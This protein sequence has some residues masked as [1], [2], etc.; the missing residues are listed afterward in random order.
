[1]NRSFTTLVLLFLCLVGTDRL[2]AQAGNALKFN[3]GQAGANEYVDLPDMP[4]A[5]NSPYTVEGWAKTTTEGRMLVD[6]FPIS[7]TSAPQGTAGNFIAIE[8]ATGG[9]L[10]YVHRA[11]GANIGGIEVLSANAVTSGNW[12]HYAAVYDSQGRASLYINGVLSAQ[13]AATSPSYIS[14]IV[15]GRIGNLHSNNSRKFRGDLDEL[16]LWSRA[17]EATDISAL[18]NKTFTDPA[19]LAAPTTCLAAYYKFNES[20]GT[21]LADA[22]GNGYTGM[23][24]GTTAAN[25]VTSTAPV[26]SQAAPS[27]QTLGTNTNYALDFDGVDDYLNLPSLTFFQ[28]S[29]FSVEGWFSTTDNT[30]GIL[31]EAFPGSNGQYL[32]VEVLANGTMRVIYR[33]NAGSSGGTLLESPTTVNN[34]AW[35]H[36][37]VVLNLD[38]TLSFYIDG[39]HQ[40]TENTTGRITAATVQAGIGR[41]FNG[42][43]NTYFKGKID[44]IRLWSRTLAA[45]D[46]LDLYNETFTNPTSVAN[47]LK[48]YYTFEESFGTTVGDKTGNGNGAT[49]TN[50]DN[51]DWVVS[52]AGVTAALAPNCADLGGDV[53]YALDFDGVDDFV[54]LPVLTAFDNST[55]TVE[56]WF[57]TEPGITSGVIFDAYELTA[58]DDLYPQGNYITVEVLNGGQIHV[59]YRSPAAKAGG[60]NLYSTTVVNGGGW[61]H[62]ALV[63]NFDNTLSLYINGIEEDTSSGT[64]NRIDDGS[65]YARLGSLG[66]RARYFDGQIDELR[67]WSRALAPAD[68][69]DHYND[70]FS[71]PT[72]VG[73][74]LDVYYQFQESVVSTAED[75][76]G[77]GNNGTL[78]NMQDNDYVLSGASVTTV[79]APNCADLSGDIDYA[80]DF[81]GVNDYVDLPTLSFLANTGFSVEGWFQA[82][83]TST[84][85]VLFEAFPVSGP[86]GLNYLTVEVIDG[87]ILFGKYRSPANNAGGAELFTPASVA[88]G[89]WH[90]YAVV[91]SEDYK[92]FSLY[93][94]GVLVDDFNGSLNPIPGDVDAALG[95]LSNGSRYWE[96]QIDETRIWSGELSSAGVAQVYDESFTN[97]GDASGCLGAY[98]QFEESIGT[99]ATDATGNGNTATLVGMENNDYVLSTAPFSPQPVVACAAVLPVELVSFTATIVNGTVE[100]AWETASEQGN[101]GFAVLHSTDGKVWTELGFVVGA[102]NSATLQRYG[103]THTQPVAGENLYQLRQVDFDGAHAYSPIEIVTVTETASALR[104]SPNPVR[105]GQLSVTVPLAGEAA[106]ELR[107]YSVRGELV[108]SRQLTQT[109]TTVPTAHLPKGVYVAVAVTNGVPVTR[110]VVIQ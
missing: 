83:N 87:G 39:V 60:A 92:T 14:E 94:D 51:A 85:G 48:A 65:V 66:S 13:S 36:F 2:Y 50:M 56:S 31:F 16:R 23:V 7:G 44:E 27:C 102:G 104:I 9:R 47:C 86:S 37:A 69:L 76:S 68:V 71:N 43:S 82:A 25:W 45:E 78:V 55:F 3:G 99:T 57:R 8:V 12:F 110:K 58:P 4:F 26:T 22:S 62:V 5:Q 101:Q 19:T 80:L 35:K 33:P 97:P 29:A 21:T 93:L 28:N 77:N 20:S 61:F 100:L 107:M 46:V 81:D 89:N 108:L 103:F 91:L 53:N 95:R 96:G 42:D 6:F 38:N 30:Y 88:D 90:H 63:L 41:R 32:S 67:V 70:A 49:M 40:D 11:N 109:T 72:A 54:A 106:A 84:T 64:V 73:Q 75:A 52:N 98:Y 74:C 15:D 34:G 17:L 18:Y 59:V 79:T 10:R 24:V 1:M 105:N